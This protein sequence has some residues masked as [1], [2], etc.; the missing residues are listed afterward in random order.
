MAGHEVA[1][2]YKQEC[3]VNASELKSTLERGQPVFGMMISMMENM[4]WMPVLAATTLDFV[5]VDTEHGSRDRREI[6]NHVIMGKAAGKTVIVRVPE[7]NPLWVAEA[8]DAGADGVLVPYCESV[9]DV[10][11]CAWKLQVHP[12]KGE[13]FDRVAQGGDYPSPKSKAYLEKRNANRLFILGIES[14]PA[15]DNLEALVTAGPIDGVF[16]GPND[17]TTSLGIPDEVDNPIYIDVLKKIIAVSES[18]GKPVM[19]HQQTMETSKKAIE[20]GARW[21]LH[22]TDASFIRNGVNS[23][24][25]ALR[26]IA[27]KKWEV[28]SAK[29]GGDMGAVH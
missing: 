27:S 12:L 20:L 23:D 13:Y 6:A 2:P 18:H 10:R 25:A 26:E 11:A 8:V 17:M 24:F 14:K 5:V 7:P 22:S 21:I 29:G 9:E 28:A 4:R 16:V 19:I 15:V 3:A 1:K